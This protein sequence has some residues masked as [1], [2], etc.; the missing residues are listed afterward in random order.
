M[1]RDKKTCFSGCSVTLSPSSSP[2]WSCGH[3][4]QRHLQKAIVE[5][6][7]KL[8]G[9]QCCS[10]CSASALLHSLEDAGRKAQTQGV[11]WSVAVAA[12]CYLLDLPRSAATLVIV[13]MICKFWAALLRC[14]SLPHFYSDQRLIKRFRHAMSYALV[15]NKFMQNPWKFHLP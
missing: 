10:S 13:I 3:H 7:A 5:S 14:N 12:G 11:S 8:L 2:C 6:T 15:C 1:L 9:L 4:S